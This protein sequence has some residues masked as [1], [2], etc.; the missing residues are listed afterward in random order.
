MRAAGSV[1][2]ALT[3]SCVVAVAARGSERRPALDLG[4]S[5][6][7][8]HTEPTGWDEFARQQSFGAD[9]SW[10]RPAWPLF[11]ALD[12]HGGGKTN[13]GFDPNVGGTVYTN[14]GTHIEVALGIR[15]IG[16]SRRSIVSLGSGLAFAYGAFAKDTLRV[17]PGQALP[18]E[19][20]TGFGPWL[21]AGIRLRFGDWY[22]AGLGARITRARGTLYGHDVD[23]GGW[24]A[25]LTV[26]GATWP[27]RSGRHA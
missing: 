21:D 26:L 19:N 24:Q 18:D 11:L 4:I 15:W 5:F 6:G 2:V 25:Y 10:R 22:S 17:P 8:R 20:G 23:L 9:A 16:Y 3:V 27:P 1:L 12:F 13:S 7:I 14:S